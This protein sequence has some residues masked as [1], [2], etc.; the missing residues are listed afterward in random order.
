MSEGHQE[1]E[2]GKAGWFRCA[3]FPKVSSP[4]PPTT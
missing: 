2:G 4:I 1:L 3:A